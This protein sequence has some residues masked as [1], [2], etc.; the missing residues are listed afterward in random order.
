MPT[1]NKKGTY[2]Y[3]YHLQEDFD[4]LWEGPTFL[5]KAERAIASEALVAWNGDNR[6]WVE[7]YAWPYAWPN[8]CETF[9]SCWGMVGE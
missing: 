5:I 6:A 1:R 2:L 4:N 3:A 9:R 8:M 7:G